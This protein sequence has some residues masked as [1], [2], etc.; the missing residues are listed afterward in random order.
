MP[1][2]AYPI[3]LG[4][5]GGDF[6]IDL[7]D[8]LEAE[9]VEMISRRESFEPAETGVFQAP[10]Q[11]HMAVHPVSSNDKRREAH[12]DLEGNSRFLGQNDDRA[13]LFGDR[14]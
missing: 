3:G 8:V 2:F 5:P 10:R 9:G 1:L 11:N 6:V 12:S 7:V 4:E 14:Q 13:V